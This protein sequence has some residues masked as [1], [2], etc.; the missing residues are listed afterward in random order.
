MF[1]APQETAPHWRQFVPAGLLLLASVLAITFLVAQPAKGQ[2][3]LAVL[4]PPWDGPLQ[5]A[6]L[7]ARAGGVLVDSGG[8]PSVFIVASNRP[9]FTAALYHAGAWLV[10]N[11]ITAHG[12]LS[13]QPAKGI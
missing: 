3:Q 1:A 6:S 7:V 10:M 2:K 4:L 13:P 12:C 5:A 8:I 9:D 11:P